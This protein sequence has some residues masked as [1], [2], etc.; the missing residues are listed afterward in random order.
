[1]RGT[2]LY[3][4]GDVS[5]EEVPEPKIAKPTDAILPFSLSRYKETSMCNQ[6]NDSD[7]ERVPAVLSRREALKAGA[8]A[9]IMPNR[10]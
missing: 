8:A 2:V 9:A 1:M 3:G 7:Q 5:F 4:A 10:A 6:H